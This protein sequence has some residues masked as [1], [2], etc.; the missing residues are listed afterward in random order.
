MPSKFGY[1]TFGENLSLTSDGHRYTARRLDPETVGSSSQP[2]GLYYYRARTYSPT[3]GRFLQPD[4]SGYPAGPLRLFLWRSPS[5]SRCILL[6]NERDA[7]ALDRGR[8]LSL[9]E[10]ADRLVRRRARKIGANLVTLVVAVVGPKTIWLLT[11]RRLSYGGGR[12]PKDDARKVMILETKDKGRAILGYAGLGATARETEPSDWMSA[13]LRGRNL[14]L[15]QSLGVLADAMKREFP[16]HMLQMP[17]DGTPSHNIVVPAFLGGEP[18][19]YTIG[20]ATARDRKTHAFGYW[21]H[22]VGTTEVGLSG[23]GG[24]YLLRT[25]HEWKHALVRAVEAH[26]SGQLSA[27]AVADHLAKL[28]Y[29][30]S[31]HDRTVGPRCVVVWRG[32]AGGGGGAAYT[33]RTRDRRGPSLPLIAGGTDLAA[34]F[35][36]LGTIKWSGPLGYDE[37]P[38]LADIPT[39][40]DEK[41]R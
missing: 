6:Q 20:L 36:R 2:S 1:Q 22:E 30:V 25:S 10:R 9:G 31:R 18:K 17:G 12:G 32:K 39:T 5:L 19:L 4:P 40:P 24:A 16:P 33:R 26:D 27:N 8:H 23:S 3:W 7:S 15:E 29:G 35:T 41:L 37:I 14:P 11:D 13:V 38:S 28:N 34:I 21:S